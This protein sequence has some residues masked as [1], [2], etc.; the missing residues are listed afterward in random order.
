MTHTEIPAIG[1]LVAEVLESIAL[2]TFLLSAVL[3]Q[4]ETE[5]E[6]ASYVC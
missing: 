2:N 6:E 3:F 5:L 1:G 4:S